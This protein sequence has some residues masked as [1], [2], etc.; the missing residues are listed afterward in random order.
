MVTCERKVNKGVSSVRLKMTY[1]LDV[2]D[3][4]NT[5]SATRE[6]G[7]VNEVVGGISRVVGA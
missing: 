6:E 3:V 5:Q 4:S 2:V 1:I 7:V